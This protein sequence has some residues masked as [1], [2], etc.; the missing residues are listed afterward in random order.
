MTDLSP[1]RPLGAPGD[2]AAARR[3]LGRQRKAVIVTVVLVLLIAGGAATV[4]GL[5]NA[6]LFFRNADEAIAARSE[7][8]DRRFR[9]QGRVVPA[10]VAVDGGVTVFEVI[11]NC[12]SVSVRHTVDPPDLFE[13]PWIPVVLE[14]RWVAGDVVTVSGADTHFFAS[15]NMLVKHT[16]EYEAA[17]ADRLD[18]PAAPPE[19]FLDDCPFEVPR[20]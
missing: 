2:R 9:L 11:H 16:N 14:G 10:S 18:D 20:L 8:G 3:Q 19:S 6:T 4:A 7:L 15:D 1:R 17:N 12:A 5:R 13:S